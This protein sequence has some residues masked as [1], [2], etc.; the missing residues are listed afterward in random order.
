MGAPLLF[1]PL[2][3]LTQD[4]KVYGRPQ[5]LIH[6]RLE[7]YEETT[8]KR[9]SAY[10]FMCEK[11]VMG[12]EVLLHLYFGELGCKYCNHSIK[13]CDAFRSGYPMTG[14]CRGCSEEHNASRWVVPT[15][16]YI[17]Y[18][19][20]KHLS[21]GLEVQTHELSQDMV[22]QAASKYIRALL[23]LRRIYPW[24]SAL[25]SV[26]KAG[27]SVDLS[28]LPPRL[29]RLKNAGGARTGEVK[30]FGVS[31]LLC[32]EKSLVRLQ[33][34]EER[35]SRPGIGTCEENKGNSLDYTNTSDDSDTDASDVPKTV[36]QSRLKDRTSQPVQVKCEGSEVAGFLDSRYA[37]LSNTLEIVKKEIEEERVLSA[38]P[39]QYSVK[40]E[41]SDLA[42][43]L[44]GRDLS[45][46]LEIVKEEIKEERDLSPQPPA[47][48][49]TQHITPQDSG[50]CS[51]LQQTLQKQEEHNAT[52]KKHKHHLTPQESGKHSMSPPVSSPHPKQQKSQKLDRK[53]KQEDTDRS[54]EGEMETGMSGHL[55]L[56][57]SVLSSVWERYVSVQEGAEKCGEEIRPENALD[58]KEP[59]GA[60]IKSQNMEERTENKDTKG[61]KKKLEKEKKRR[62]SLQESEKCG[63]EETGQNNTLD[64]GKEC[65][66]AMINS[67]LKL[68]KKKRR[69]SLQ[70]KSE[71][72]G[73]EEIG[74]RNTLDNGKECDDAMINSILKLEKKKKCGFSLQES[75]KCDEEIGQKNTLDNGKEPDDAVIESILKMEE[76][77][78]HRFS[79]QESEKCGA[80]EEIRPENT[81]GDIK[82]DNKARRSMLRLE[83]KK[84]RTTTSFENFELVELVSANENTEIETE[85]TQ[86]AAEEKA[87]NVDKK[88]H[89]KRKKVK[90]ENTIESPEI[91]TENTQITAETTQNMEE[92]TENKDTKGHK[93]RSKIRV[94]NFFGNPESYLTEN[95]DAKTHKRKKT[96]QINT[97]ENT[98][99]DF[100]EN[101]DSDRH[102][103]IRL[104]NTFDNTQ[105]DTKENITI[106]T[107]KR[108]KIKVENNIGSSGNITTNT[109]DAIKNNLKPENTSKTHRKKKKQDNALENT[110]STLENTKNI[111]RNTKNA[112]ENI[113][114]ILE[115]TQHTIGNTQHILKNTQSILET[116]QNTQIHLENVLREYSKEREQEYTFENTHCT[117]K[118]DRGSNTTQQNT[119]RKKRKQ[120]NNLENTSS[121][122][123]HKTGKR[124]VTVVNP[125]ELSLPATTDTDTLQAPHRRET[126]TF[127]TSPA[128]K[129]KKKRVKIEEICIETPVIE[130]IKGKMKSSAPA[131]VERNPAKECK[132]RKRLK[133]EEISVQVPASEENEC[134]R[135]RTESIARVNEETTPVKKRSKKREKLETPIITLTSPINEHS[136]NKTTP[137]A[138]QKRKKRKLQSMSISTPASMPHILPQATST[139]VNATN[140]LPKPQK[141]RKGKHIPTSEGNKGTPAIIPL[142]FLDTPTKK[143]TLPKPQKKKKGK[144]PPTSEGNEGAPA[145][146]PLILLDAPTKENTLPKTQ[147]KRKDKHTA[148][149]AEINLITKPC[150]LSDPLSTPANIATTLSKSL[151]KKK[152]KNTLAYHD[153]ISASTDHTPANLEDTPVERHKKK[154]KKMKTQSDPGSM[155]GAPASITS[156]PVVA[157]CSNPVE[158]PSPPVNMDCSQTRPKKKKKKHIPANTSEIRAENIETPGNT[159]NTSVKPYMKI[160]GKK[161]KV[162]PVRVC[163]ALA[164]MKDTTEKAEMTIK[165]MKKNRN[166][167]K[168]LDKIANID[169]NTD[170]QCTKEKDT[171]KRKHN[172]AST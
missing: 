51:A 39:L 43:S 108:R 89:K 12:A 40:H 92:R 124:K 137:A 75:E 73:D 3:G 151:K 128:K 117:Q 161:N 115:N 96:K 76:K 116:T 35:S 102:R 52:P 15:M 84:N 25:K 141:K 13:N 30:M 11:S 86:N 77:E 114:I 100:I 44:D 135:A 106:N 159:C 165:K 103:K 90:T 33:A 55:Q 126:D 127:P 7:A 139:P 68:E 120:E 83:R 168:A 129:N 87:E 158:E 23:P 29:K 125:S 81:L 167:A 172:P 72:C 154:S 146:I 155:V 56:G 134:S 152:E 24:R 113:L 53:I 2:L 48:R 95:T 58:D 66:D 22:M 14:V 67:I 164:N 45:D 162:I 110:H 49:N 97:F 143:N 142:I 34:M 148:V 153:D 171:K 21:I 98:Q 9:L 20:R 32:L 28:N 105:N 91:E 140:T 170:K 136:M 112:L 38:Q 111:F 118:Q 79:L 80:E 18:H 78:K 27:T 1:G 57:E 107:H 64:N 31:G 10:C 101:I 147:K 99:D 132:K 104:V 17:T 65:D 74:Q 85:N 93:K 26:S 54:N 166:P 41:V 60:M 130:D 138:E 157:P 133:I 5:P 94:V 46:M 150:M 42:D 131:N 149:T 109:Q 119:Y 8:L 122:D 69:F 4:P 71:K 6:P 88:T 145:I 156:F 160:K 36:T 62:F 61:H 163:T 70:E 63:E 47:R 19:T 169:N 50:T 82:A 59:D 123:T 144:H 37:E 16:K 121:Q